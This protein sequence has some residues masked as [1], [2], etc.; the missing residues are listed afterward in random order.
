VTCGDPGMPE[1]HEASC[2]AEN[3]P[4]IPKTI[5]ERAWSSPVFYRPEAIGRL[6]GSLSF[7]TRPQTDQLSLM[8][9]IARLPASVDF[10]SQ[11]LEIEIRDDDLVYAATLPAGSLEPTK[12][13]FRYR[14]RAGSIDG[15]KS[16]RIVRDSRGTHWVRLRTSHVDLSA[17][18]RVDHPVEVRLTIGDFDAAHVRTWELRGQTLRTRPQGDLRK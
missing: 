18:E 11:P 13:G 5:Q 9:H 10:A 12:W 7:G 3:Y 15:V 14:D 2:C 1:D 16:V 4:E 8:A 6:A 17:A